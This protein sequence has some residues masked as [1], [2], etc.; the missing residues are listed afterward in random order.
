MNLLNIITYR[1]QNQSNKQAYI[2]LQDGE[3]DS[4]VSVTYGELNK[5][6]WSI[7]SHL[8]SF[9]GERAVLLYHSGLEFIAAFFGCL[10]AGVIAVPVY[11][12]RR[13]QKLSRLLSIVNDAQVKVALTTTSLLSDIEKRW[14]EEPE[15]AR[16]KLVATDAIESNIQEF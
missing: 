3:I 2:F 5:Q 1:A 6:A 16:L 4:A 14:W 8:Q 10:Y 7:A 15:L 11:P 13:Y 9:R 12:P